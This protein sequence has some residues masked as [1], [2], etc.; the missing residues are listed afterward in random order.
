V[1]IFGFPAAASGSVARIDPGTNTVTSQV[2]VGYDPVGMAV[3][4]DA[5]YVTLS[6]DPT[7][8]Q[9]RA[10]AVSSRI[11]V[12]M[13]SLDLAVANGSLWVLH[14]VGSGIGGAKLYAGGVTRV[15]I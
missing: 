8:V 1:S 11:A 9:L 4:G 15:N 10:G 14:P 2:A 7:I 3:V 12:G 6:G 5:L 13:K